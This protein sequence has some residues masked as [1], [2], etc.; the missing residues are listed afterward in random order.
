METILNKITGKI[1]EALK[2]AG[3]ELEEFQLQFALGKA[4][5]LD[6][7]ED[8]KKKMH[9]TILEF[10]EKLNAEK[11]N[12]QDLKEKI[13]LLLSILTRGKAETKEIF[14]EQKKELLKV[15][16][17][18]EEILEQHTLELTL[19]SYIQI[20]LSKFR[21]KLE[22]IS[23]RFELKKVNIKED[24]RKAKN[25]FLESLEGIKKEFNTK[26]CSKENNRKEFWDEMSHA[27]IHLKKAF[28]H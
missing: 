23:L 12:F 21:I 16:K 1:V 27:F 15:I 28:G 10:K 20:E 7:Y 22:I 18:I 3:H 14:D 19:Q 6:K 13:E 8:V 4:E 26:E 17:E 11:E 2:I 24:I 5:A 9:G 25:I